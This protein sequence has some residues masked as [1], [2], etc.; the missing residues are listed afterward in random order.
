MLVDGVSA[1]TTGVACLP[2]AAA[3][4]DL[5]AKMAHTCLLQDMPPWDNT[6]SCSLPGYENKTTGVFG[7]E[8]GLLFV[9]L[10]F[11]LSYQEQSVFLQP[12]FIV[13][14]SVITLF[15][16]DSLCSQGLIAW[17]ENIKEWLSAKILSVNRWS[18]TG[19]FQLRR[20]YFEH[21]PEKCFLLKMCGLMG[22][23]HLFIR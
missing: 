18:L 16:F 15:A 8:W 6:T 7:G 21:L 19:V 13:E 4:M 2:N 11:Q 12:R 5:C 9:Y 10:F 14:M 3:C 17:D 20:D 23:R 1:G 22:L